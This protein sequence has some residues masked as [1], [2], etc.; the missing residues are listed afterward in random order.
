MPYIK[1]TQK[2]TIKFPCIFLQMKL[3]PQKWNKMKK[4]KKVLFKFNSQYYIELSS[5]TIGKLSNQPAKPFHP[6]IKLT[7]LM[8]LSI[9][10]SL[11]YILSRW[12]CVTTCQTHFFLVTQYRTADKDVEENNRDPK[13]VNHVCTSFAFA[14]FCP[15]I[16]LS[17]MTSTGEEHVIYIFAL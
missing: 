6:I 16:R 17:L 4:K 1:F 2:K 10:A 9:H 15:L 8:L 11:L 14:I 3:F 12:N 5:S 7:P 13:N